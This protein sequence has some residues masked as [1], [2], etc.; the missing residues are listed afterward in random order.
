[1]LYSDTAGIV[2]AGDTFSVPVG[3]TNISNSPH[4]ITDTLTVSV[5]VVNPSGRTQQMFPAEI[6][7][8]KGDTASA[9][10]RMRAATT[11]IDTVQF[12]LRATTAEVGVCDFATGFRLYSPDGAE[13]ASLTVQLLGGYFPDYNI[14]PSVQFLSV[15]GIGA[16]TVGYNGIAIDPFL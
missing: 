12:R 10:L 13:W 16:D 6:E 4:A 9:M 14:F 15:D 5:A 8:V 11:V 2:R 3:I 1:V 7:I